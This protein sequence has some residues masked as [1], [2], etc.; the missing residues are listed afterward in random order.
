MRSMV[1]C[2]MLKKSL[3]AS[4]RGEVFDG[5]KPIAA[6]GREFIQALENGYPKYAHLHDV[7]LDVSCNALDRIGYCDTSSELLPHILSHPKAFLR[8]SLLIVDHFCFSTGT[9]KDLPLHIH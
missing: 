7:I 5:P 8:T 3:K 2:L 9:D 1:V 6:W 4:F